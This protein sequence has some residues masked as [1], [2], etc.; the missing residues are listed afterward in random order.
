MEYKRA[1]VLYSM[2]TRLYI[3]SIL[4]GQQ[5]IDTLLYFLC[6]QITANTN[7]ELMT[8]KKTFKQPLF[9][10]TVGL[11]YFVCNLISLVKYNQ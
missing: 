10:L 7:N 1:S 4:Q 11:I 6:I 9:T 3:Y 2:Y 5:S 8:K